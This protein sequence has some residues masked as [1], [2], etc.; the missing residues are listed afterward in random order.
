[1][2]F[3]QR[4]II[5]Y[6]PQGSGKGTQLDLLK[7]YLTSQDPELPIIEISMGH[8]FRDLAGKDSF[9]GKTIRSYLSAGELAPL[10]MAIHLWGDHIATHFHE[11]GVFLMDGTP[12][13]I[14]EAQILDSAF[15]TYGVTRVDIINLTLP[16]EIAIERM[17]KRGRE[18]DNPE[19]IQK[20]LNAFHS[21]TKPVLEHLKYHRRYQIHTVDASQTP[22]VIHAEIRRSLL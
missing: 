14:E 6:G 5:F 12:R 10:F 3:N 20:R 18:D 15:E 9:L 1:M 11:E 21:S 8:M 2:N 16:D 13:R 22:E 4:A 7:H 19:T 17:Q